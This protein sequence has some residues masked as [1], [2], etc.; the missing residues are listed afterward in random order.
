MTREEQGAIVKELREM[1]GVGM[2]DCKKAL[3]QT[4]WN[5]E[6]AINYLKKMTYAN[7][8]SHVDYF[9]IASK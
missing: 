1:T 2:M 4:K 7:K 3:E 9:N 6:E 8:L 5:T